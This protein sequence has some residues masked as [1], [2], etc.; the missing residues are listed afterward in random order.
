MEQPGAKRNKSIP[1]P[2]SIYMDLSNQPDPA[3]MSQQHVSTQLSL[4]DSDIDK[5]A[6]AIES[7]LMSKFKS[8]VTKKYA[9]DC[10]ETSAKFITTDTE[11]ASDINKTRSEQQPRQIM[12]RVS[13]PNTKIRILRCRKHLKSS[14]NYNNVYIN[15]DL[16]KYRNRLYY[17]TRCLTKQ[18]GARQCWTVNGKIYLNETNGTV[19]YINTAHDFNEAVIK[20]KLD[21]EYL[22]VDMLMNP[23]YEHQGGHITSLLTLDKNFFNF[24]IDCI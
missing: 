7:K 8:N 2:E 6:E 4:S 16:T 24:E 17:H 3:D 9:A 10:S 22:S 20:A 11:Q 18:K 1:V 5:I 21:Y 12:V 14:R 19:Y 15:E 13:N 23:S